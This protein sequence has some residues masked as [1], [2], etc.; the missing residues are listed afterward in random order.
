[1]LKKG[2][3]DTAISMDMFLREGNSG[4]HI[5][6]LRTIAYKQMTHNSEVMLNI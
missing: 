6:V 4:M 5:M 3:N 1:M 2:H